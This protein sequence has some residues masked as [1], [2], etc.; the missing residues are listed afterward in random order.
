[1]EET[2]ARINTL[3]PK[4]VFLT[5]TSGAGKTFLSNRL[6]GYKVLELDEVV[7]KLGREF[8][9]EEPEEF[10]VY[11]NNLPEPFMAAFVE[12]IH[13]FFMQNSESPVVV[14][15][16]IA[17]ADLVRRIF[18]GLYAEFTF[19]YLYP[20]DVEQYVMRM[21]K[22]FK[23]EK[24]SNAHALAIWT[25]VTPEIEQ[26]AFGSVE[27]KEFMERM[28]HWSM[29]KSALRYAYFEKSGLDMVRVDV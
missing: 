13:T 26:A 7:K 18:S 21:M 10:K 25:Q 11:K 3:R 22:R 19:V 27:M 9:M 29:D 5:A 16:A 17:D 1:M 28:A 24:E 15:G 6:A 20:V 23:E 4:Y 12:R 8:G 14:E 2:I